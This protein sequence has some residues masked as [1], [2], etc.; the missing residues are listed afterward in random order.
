MRRLLSVLLIITI[1]LPLGAYSAAAD[2]ASAV[3]N[4]DILRILCIGNSLMLD[5]YCYVPMLL[6]EAL[7]DKQIIFG[8]C[9][10]DGYTIA[11][12]AAQFAAKEPTQ[13]YS[14]W[15]PDAHQY[16]EITSERSIT[17][18]ELLVRHPWDVVILH[19]S[20]IDFRTVNGALTHAQTD[21]AN[22]ALF[23][24]QIS[25]MLNHPFSFL[26]NVCHTD[27]VT[28]HNNSLAETNTRQKA[29]IAYTKY[30]VENMP[31]FQDAVPTGTAIQNL[32][33]IPQ[34]ENVGED[35]WLAFDSIHLQHG[36]ATLCGSYA[37]A[38]KIMETFGFLSRNFKFA[39]TPTDEI[40]KSKVMP[41]WT[42]I[43]NTVVGVTAD[44]MYMAQKCAAM[45]LKYPYTITDC[46]LMVTGVSQELPV[47]EPEGLGP[48][49]IAAS[50][51]AA[52]LGDAYEDLLDGDRTAL[53]NDL[54]I[55]RLSSKRPADYSNGQ[56]VAIAATN[57]IDSDLDHT[58]VG[59]KYTKTNYTLTF[60][61]A[62]YTAFGSEGDGYS[63]Y[64]L[65][66][67]DFPLT[68]PPDA[69][70]ITVANDIDN[71]HDAMAAVFGE[72]YQDGRAYIA[73]LVNKDPEEV[74]I[75][76]C[77]ML[78]AYFDNP[79]RLY[80]Q[81]LAMVWQDG[82]KFYFYSPSGSAGKGVIQANDQFV[83]C[84]LTSFAGFQ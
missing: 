62:N 49:D 31:Y 36:I 4:G 33:S 59:V 45:A 24:E 14:E 6:E 83:V 21:Y 3:G 58:L 65:N 70:I 18:Q 76:I 26:L 79:D 41:P 55:L 5:S 15:D 40:I 23:C 47:S 8:I 61:N 16:R 51:G 28:A 25:S 77:V 52:N 57:R 39:F 64:T 54:T 30:C 71:T 56:L 53:P 69:E 82:N 17:L 7:P 74:S 37:A 66:F 19:Q 9:H 42:G 11:Q 50:R 27:S 29:L 34:M 13:L 75:Q 32:R 67:S 84:E 38:A 43:G 10:N 44:N 60:A 12:Y 73:Y 46:S 22:T 81:F 72:N 1:I 68:P 80:N 2:G 20:Y 35:G 78:Y 63:V 48:I